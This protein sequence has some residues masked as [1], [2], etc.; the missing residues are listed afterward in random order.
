VMSSSPKTCQISLIVGVRASRPVRTTRGLE[1]AER[2]LADRRE[3]VL[4][5]ITRMNG[6]RGMVETLAQKRMFIGSLPAHAEENKREI[7]MLTLNAADLMPVEAPWR[8]T[9]QSPG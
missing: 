7:D 1:E 4:N 5:T 8:G 2:L 3:R 6:A 9:P